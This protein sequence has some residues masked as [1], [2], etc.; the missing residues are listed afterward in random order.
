MCVDMYSIADLVGL[1]TAYRIL[2]TSGH[3]LALPFEQKVE[4]GTENRWRENESG[5]NSSPGLQVPV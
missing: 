3:W 1:W 5:Q 2:S 4:E